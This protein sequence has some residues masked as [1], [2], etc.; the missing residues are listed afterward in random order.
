MS[1]TAVAHLNGHRQIG[2]VDEEAGGQLYGRVCNSLVYI[3]T[4]VGPFLR[5]ERF[6]T[7]YRSCVVSAQDALEDQA[8]RGRL[9]LGEWHTHPAA[10]AR[11]SKDDHN[12]L[13]ELLNRSRL[14]TNSLFMIIVSQ[15]R[16]PDGWYIESMDE[17]NLST[18]WVSRRF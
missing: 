16:M 13:L 1:A 3:D 9:Y 8:K 7:S 4:A 17:T 15:D 10:V 2:R 18:I 5:D 12:S 14:N 6:R 11:P